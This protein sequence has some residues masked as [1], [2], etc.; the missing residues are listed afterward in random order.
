MHIAHSYDTDPETWDERAAWEQVEWAF[1]QAAA[2][3]EQDLRTDPIRQ[4]RLL[5]LGPDFADFE[6]VSRPLPFGEAGRPATVRYTY[7]VF[8]DSFR[9]VLMSAQARRWCA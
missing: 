2:E 3:G 7:R 5:K 4:L 6:L 8:K 1:A 9:L